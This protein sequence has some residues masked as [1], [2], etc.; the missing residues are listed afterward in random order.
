MSNSGSND[1]IDGDLIDLDSFSS[2]PSSG[3]FYVPISGVLRRAGD[4][5]DRMD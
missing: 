1:G 2:G 4:T 5:I 3:E